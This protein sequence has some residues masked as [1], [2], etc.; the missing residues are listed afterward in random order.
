MLCSTQI[1]A[2]EKAQEAQKA[3]SGPV[4]VASHQLNICKAWSK[5]L[6]L[7]LPDSCLAVLAK[8]ID[9]K[10]AFVVSISV[11]SGDVIMGAGYGYECNGTFHCASHLPAGNL[12]T[13][14]L[15]TIHHRVLSL[16]T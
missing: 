4:G 11:A 7:N 12:S 2:L 5:N 3:S 10:D 14:S 6:D 1:E 13:Y 15:F 16:K 9:N 8:Y